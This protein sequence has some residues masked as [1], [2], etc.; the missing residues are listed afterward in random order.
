MAT[1]YLRNV[2]EDIK[3]HFKALCVLRGETITDEIIKLMRE[4]VEKSGIG[5][6]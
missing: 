1:L 3:K 6:S 2:P 5:K 4:E